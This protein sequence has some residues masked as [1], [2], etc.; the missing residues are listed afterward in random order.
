MSKQK[1]ERTKPHV[2]VG[3]KDEVTGSSPVMSSRKKCFWI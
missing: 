1:F 3:S 2:N